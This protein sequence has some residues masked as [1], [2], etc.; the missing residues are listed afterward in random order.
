MEGVWPKRLLLP[1]RQRIENHPL[2]EPFPR[3]M[4]RAVPGGWAAAYPVVSGGSRLMALQQV[5][6]RR[7][8]FTR[9]G[10]VYLGLVGPSCQPIPMAF[11]NVCPDKQLY[12]QFVCEIQRFR[13]GIY[14][15]DGTIPPSAVDCQGRHFT[16]ADYSSWHLIL[17]NQRIEVVGCARACLHTGVCRVSDLKLAEMM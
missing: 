10:D 8:L 6:P 2:S 16:L 4:K 7:S 5:K 14:L 3:G 13:G 11:A 17:L 15:E 12:E 9:L 1:H